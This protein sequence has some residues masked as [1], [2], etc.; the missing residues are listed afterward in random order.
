LWLEEEEEYEI[1][2]AQLYT[3]ETTMG[4]GQLDEDDLIEHILQSP[5]PSTL[6]LEEMVKETKRNHQIDLCLADSNPTAVKNIEFGPKSILKINPSFYTSRRKVVKHAKGT[7]GC[8][9]LELEGNEGSAPLN[10]YSPHLYQRR[11][12]TNLIT[13]KEN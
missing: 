4:G 9:C 10:V 11:L 2:S 1:Y 12:Q 3:L 6:S 8:L 7:S 13:P 5:T